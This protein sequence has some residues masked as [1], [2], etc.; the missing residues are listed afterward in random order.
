MTA[1]LSGACESAVAG[2]RLEMVI[3]EV[4][5]L[6]Y[7]HFLL[8]PSTNA[9]AQF[10]KNGRFKKRHLYLRT[11]FDFAAQGSSGRNRGMD[12][13]VE[14]STSPKIWALFSNALRRDKVNLAK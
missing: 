13:S 9:L 4:L 6:I 8:W 14:D 12:Q 7:I 1:T 2:V 11:F 10:A 3:M 5:V